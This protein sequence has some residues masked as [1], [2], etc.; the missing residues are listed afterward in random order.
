M[1]ER[2]RSSLF[3]RPGALLVEETAPRI[4]MPSPPMRVRAPELDLFDPVVDAPD[5]DDAPAVGPLQ[6]FVRAPTSDVGA[7]VRDTSPGVLSADA[8]EELGDAFGRSPPKPRLERTELPEPRVGVSVRAAAPARAAPTPPAV[9]ASPPLVRQRTQGIPTAAA[10]TRVPTLRVEAPPNPFADDENTNVELMPF[11]LSEPP[12]GG[13]DRREITGPRVPPW[14]EARR[15]AD[16][17][18]SFPGNARIPPRSSTFEGR[19]GE[20]TNPGELLA[21]FGELVSAPAPRPSLPLSAPSIAPAISP[22]ILHSPPVPAAPPPSSPP[23]T[24]A[25][26]TRPPPT[27][28]LRRSLARLRPSRRQVVA[29]ATVIVLL[30]AGAGALRWERANPGAFARLRDRLTAQADPPVA[31]VAPAVQVDAG[32]SMV[33]AAPAGASAPVEVGTD[34][35]P[36]E[37]VAAAPEVAPPVEAAPSA[38]PIAA[39]LP[40][41]APAS[42]TPASSKAPES[43]APESTLPA[44][45]APGSKAPTTLP[46]ADASALERRGAYQA[47]TGYLQVIC[48]RKATIYVDDVKKGSTAD[49]V[50]IELTA[51]THRV[52][53]VANGRS[54]TMEVRIDA[55]RPR[56]VQFELR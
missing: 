33:G 31:T 43:K 12:R 28:P 42:S 50:P 55:G 20:P 3:G 51:G 1:S 37:V 27:P 46:A 18:T 38:L 54:R 24:I 16:S 6:V 41:A 4:A 5:D 25:L 23:P 2:G 10:R 36:V 47:A 17:E 9:A 56:Q 48:N 14:E 34:A 26:L 45:K 44:S 8:V 32:A 15:K 49:N 11:D 29:V 22:A 53:V 40:M 30:A 39:S 13:V 52:K 21:P 35:A 7:A 19:T